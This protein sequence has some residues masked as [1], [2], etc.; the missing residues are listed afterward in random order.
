MNKAKLIKTGNGRL[1]PRALGIYDGDAK[2]GHQGDYP[3]R[4]GQIPSGTRDK[5]SIDA[6]SSD[7]WRELHGII[8]C[9]YV[10]ANRHM[11]MMFCWRV[12][13]AG[14][15]SS[16]IPGNGVRKL[17]DASVLRNQLRTPI[18]RCEE[19]SSMFSLSYETK[20]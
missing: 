7:T 11:G 1:H 12:V 15:S 8:S 18:G 6:N 16:S 10:L 5:A 9:Y 20:V 19:H 2:G 17:V 14:A 13:D 3:S 4:Y